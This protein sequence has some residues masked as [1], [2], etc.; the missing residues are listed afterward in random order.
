[1]DVSVNVIRVQHP[2]GQSWLVILEFGRRPDLTAALGRL[3]ESE[4]GFP[5]TGSDFGLLRLD[6]SIR[7]AGRD[8]VQRPTLCPCVAGWRPF[9]SNHSLPCLG[10]WE[11]S[12]QDSR[13][14]RIENHPTPQTTVLSP[15]FDWIH[16]LELCPK[17]LLLCLAAFCKP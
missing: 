16:N 12:C 8:G 6:N 4:P 3:P 17:C 15:I 1:M 13:D 2:L 9:L 14:I 10:S 5:R 7:D 11:G